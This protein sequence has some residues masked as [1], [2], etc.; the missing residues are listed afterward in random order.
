MCY[1]IA[2][3]FRNYKY[4]LCNPCQ[5]FLGIAHGYLLKQIQH[6]VQIDA[7]PNMYPVLWSGQVRQ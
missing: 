6:I 3:P 1:I 4:F 7:F 2:M 5:V